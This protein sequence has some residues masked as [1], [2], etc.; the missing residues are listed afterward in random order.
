MA[1]QIHAVV[2]QSQHLDEVFASG[3]GNPEYYEVPSLAS[4]AGDMKGVDTQA[5]VIPPSDAHDGRFEREI[6]HY[7]R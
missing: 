3:R 4:L 6:M 1:W 5:N 2:K 7:V